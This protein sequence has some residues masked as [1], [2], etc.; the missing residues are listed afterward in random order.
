MAAARLLGHAVHDL[1]ARRGER[2]LRHESKDLLG[3]QP[4]EEVAGARDLQHGVGLGAHEIALVRQQGDRIGAG[5]GA[6]EGLVLPAQ[7]RH[8][9]RH[10]RG[11][12]AQDRG[13][14]VDIDQLPRRTHAGVGIG[15]V[16]LAHQHDLAAHHAARGVHFLDHGGGDLGHHRTVGTARAGERRQRRDLDWVRLVRHLG[17]QDGRSGEHGGAAQESRASGDKNHFS[18][19]IPLKQCRRA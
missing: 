8:G 12:G 14:L 16:V 6:E 1:D 3:A 19:P 18:Y 13:H 10:R 5:D 7:R 4:H 9:G 17:A 15:L 11:P 2:R